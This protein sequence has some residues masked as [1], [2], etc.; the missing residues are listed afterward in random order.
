MTTIYHQRYRKLIDH[1]K[2]IV[3]EGYTE[4]HHII[5]KCMGGDNSEDNLVD[6][7][8]KAHYI[9]HLLLTKMYPENRS[10]RFA[11]SAMRM[12]TNKH[13]RKF[14]TANRYAKMRELHG[15]PITIDGNTFPS[16]KQ[17]A[18]FYQTTEATISNWRIYG[19]PDKTKYHIVIDGMT[20]TSKKE[21]RAYFNCSQSRLETWIN[22][23]GK[24]RCRMNE[25]P[26]QINGIEFQTQQSAAE[27][28]N[29]S[30]RTIATWIKTNSWQNKKWQTK[31]GCSD[32]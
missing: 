32:I 5:P 12:Q 6:L 8:A 2:S 25:S 7:P 20:F 30:R 15:S 9:A 13:T 10:I 18:D 29:V 19:K 4:R 27:Y 22:T 17:A 14:I 11:F 28:Y 31:Y 1:Y 24:S 16:G 3:C 21:A 26:C 23:G